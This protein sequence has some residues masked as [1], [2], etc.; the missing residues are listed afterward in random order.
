MADHNNPGEPRATDEEATFAEM[1]DVSGADDGSADADVEAGAAAAAAA[2]ADA[3]ADEAEVASE[4][5]AAAAEAEPA[6]EFDPALEAEIDEALA[7]VDPDA[8]GDGVIS[9][10]EQQLAERT[11]DLQRLSA[12]YTNYRR[13]VERDRVAVAE[14]ARSDAAQH[15]LPIIDD[16]EMAAQHGDLTGPLKAVSDKLQGVLGTLK[17]ESFGA[18][19][20]V[21][22]PELHEAVQDTSSGDDKVLGT[23]L[24]KGYRLNQRVLRHAMVIIADPQ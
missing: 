15:L 8:D 22:D 12:E 21:F 10:V 7:G 11:E 5:A 19:G 23:V 20:D 13:R 3:V 14:N 18:E 24:R 1:A 2:A 4:E 16:L 6:G 17:V 9:N